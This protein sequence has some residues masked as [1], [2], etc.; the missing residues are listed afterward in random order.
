M[1]KKRFSNNAKNHPWSVV[2]QI[3][4]CLLFLSVLAVSFYKSFVPYYWRWILFGAAVVM[5]I[6]QF[7][8]LKCPMLLIDRIF[9]NHPSKQ[10]ILALFTFCMVLGLGLCLF[11]SDG[12][13]HTFIGFI[14]PQRVTQEAK[15]TYRYEPDNEVVPTERY[16]AIKEPPRAI[17]K[18]VILKNTLIWLLGMIV[19]NGLLIATINRYMA[20]RAERYKRGANTYK[21]IKNHYLIIG[22]GN[23]CVPIIRNIMKRPGTDKS[24]YYLILTNQNTEAIRRGIQTQLQDAEERVVIYSGDMSAQAHLKLLNIGKALEVFILG[25]QFDRSRD[26]IN[27]ECTKAVKEIRAEKDNE[28]LRVN[29]QLDK[30]TSYSTIKRITIP[31]DYYKDGDRDVISFRPFN[32]YENWARLLWGTYHLDS[33]K[34]LDQGLLV[35]TDAEGKPQLAQKHVHL[36]IVGF[37]EMGTALLLEALR[38]CH[39]PNYNE[40]TGDNKTRITII[41]PK[42][43]MLLPKFKS[44]YPYLDQIKDIE[45][46][47]RTNKI[48]DK[49]IREMLD[50]L[51]SDKQV[52]LTIAVSFY[53]S[54]DSLSAA[55]SLPE[56]VFYHVVDKAIVPNTTTQVLVRQE[57]KNGLA[58]LMN[59][60]NGKFANLKIFGTLD[61]G[62]DD[63]LL[64]D[65]MAMCIS[66]YYHCKY[67]LNPPVDF[68]ELA[69]KDMGK[70]RQ[71]AETNWSSLNED[72]RFANRYQVEIYKTY[73]TYRT[74]LE[75]HPE[76]LY[77][78]EHMRWCA[79][80]SIT[81]YRNLAEEGIK[82]GPY[83][84]HHLIIPYHEL[85]DKE[86]GKDRDVLEIMDKVLS[87]QQTF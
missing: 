78:T 5:T 81:G 45:I 61:Q 53:D 83:Q 30:P 16:V 66:A 75:D 31:K 74:L 33:Y 4:I 52:L 15:E 25:E 28:V 76:L 62:V 73:Q 64:D 6:I 41:D 56:N 26:S 24:A 79:E 39:Y 47:F 82:N 43:P 60:E 29:V 13:R 18:S 1:S 34:T 67:D 17:K 12:V 72:K 57:I 20:T 77:Q 2:F 54:D 10:L 35:T 51:A 37:D 63:Q 44:Q 71:I 36:C 68:F 87:L 49:E 70:A 65:K 86:K 11:P 59:E 80:R 46:D 7:I 23:M 42:M 69:H 3:L 50:T 38:L 19:F 84:T 85:D 8:R 22:Y 55:L 40:S 21:N 14:N 32:F 58:D 9:A 48:E 27:L